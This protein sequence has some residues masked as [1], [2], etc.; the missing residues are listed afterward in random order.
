[1]NSA[2]ATD[3]LSD[4]LD[5]AQAFE[6]GRLPHDHRFRRLLEAG[7]TAGGARPKALI[8]DPD[9]VQWIAKFPSAARDDSHDI[10][11]LEATG[12]ALARLAG[13]NVPQA[14]LEPV[15]KRRVLLVKRFDV[16]TGTGKVP[17]RL[18]MQS[19]KSLCRERPGVYVIGYGELAGMLRRVSA[20]PAE[21]VRVLFRQAAFNA[22]IGNVDDHLKNFWV[23][24]T[25][26]GWRLSPA[27]D[28]VPDVAGGREHTL[29]F[30]KDMACPPREAL[31]RVGEAWGVRD[32]VEVLDQIIGAVLNFRAVA[33]QHE[34]PAAD[35]RLVGREIERRLELLA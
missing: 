2:T 20:A 29:A 28:L 9:G 35:I 6:A 3:A 13:L 27:F 16:I 5:A 23:L 10:V 1:V 15:G 14:R 7:G 8:S 17:G 21:D 31:I 4:L 24:H 22:A 19:F 25:P 30:D 34:V 12:L 11:G 33:Q 26:S 32:A 18:H